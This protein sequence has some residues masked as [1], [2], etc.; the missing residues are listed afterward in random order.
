MICRCRTNEKW[1]EG[2]VIRV[3]PG[4]FWARMR[5]ILVTV[6]PKNKHGFGG[7]D[8]QHTRENSRDDV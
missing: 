3:D 7:N 2:D 8:V 5:Y 4:R 6:E 1:L